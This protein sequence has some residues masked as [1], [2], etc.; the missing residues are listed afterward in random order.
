M[1][2]A[3]RNLFALVN[4]MSLYSAINVCVLSSRI[5]PIKDNGHKVAYFGDLWELLS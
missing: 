3:R 5:L 4:V 2:P 1:K